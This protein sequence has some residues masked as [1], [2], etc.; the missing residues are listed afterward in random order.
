[1]SKKGRPAK[2]VD[3]RSSSIRGI[4]WNDRLLIG[5]FVLMFLALFHAWT[6]Q[7][8]SADGNASLVSRSSFI[9]VDPPWTPPGTFSNPILHLHHFGDWTLAL[10]YS[11]YHRPYDPSLH[12][13]SPIPPFALLQLKIVSVL[14]ERLS[15]LMLGIATVV[16]WG[17]IVEYFLKSRTTLVKVQVLILTVLLTFPSIFTFD[18]GAVHLFVFGLFGYAFRQYRRGKNISALLAFVC[19][20][21]F[22]PYLIV[23][24]LWLLR[25]KRYRQLFLTIGF[26][27]ALNLVAMPFFSDNIFSG[28][29]NYLHASKEYTAAFIIPWVMSSVSFMGFISRVIQGLYGSNSSEIFLQRYIGYSWIFTLLYVLFLYFIIRNRKIPDFLVVTLLL[30]SSS[31][32]T[33]P[34]ME[35][36][37]VWAS[38]AMIF[39][40]SYFENQLKDQELDQMNP[41]D[42]NRL[43]A[44]YISCGLL[45]LVILVPYFG[46]VPVP[47]GL[48]G[49]QP[50]SYLY[51][52][53]MIPVV[54]FTLLYAFDS[55]KVIKP[56]NSEPTTS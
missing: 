28:L 25:E 17:V 35:Y 44:S 36:T 55:K 34:S 54:I 8:K 13:P 53:L 6:L 3:A 24:A 51:I 27:V 9:V 30:A 21:S 40:L 20:V 33:P 14:G 32:I 23:L 48:V 37:L 16:L 7:Y 2:K 15:F 46:L 18:R 41:H 5:Q 12:I 49:H 45:F 47:S 10:A 19:A 39:L 56:D 22:K 43:R 11:I 29:T 26:T 31:L 38:L 4:R 50:N 42:R 52:P 1:M